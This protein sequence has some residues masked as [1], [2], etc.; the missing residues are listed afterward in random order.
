MTASTTVSVLIPTFR[1]PV[2]LA[3]S[4][5]ALDAQTGLEA[6]RVEIVV[7]DN[8]PQASAAPVIAEARA[9]WRSALALTAVAEPRPGISHARNRA[10][11]EASAP[12]VVFLDDDQCPAPGW[13]AALVRVA[14]SSGAAAVFGPVTAVL[15][16]P[17]DDPVRPLYAAYFS[18][19]IQRMDGADLTDMVARLG[20]QN[21]LFNRD[22]CRWGAPPFDADLG[23][24]GGEDSVA[25]RRLTE[26]GLRLAWA[27]EALVSETV[28]AER[29]TP[30]YL[31]RR[32][33]RD[34]QI[35]AFA[36]LRLARKRPWETLLWMGIG[37]AQAGVHA[38]GWLLA[39]VRDGRASPARRVHH[40]A[41]MAGGL[42][43]VLWMGRFRYR[44]YGDGGS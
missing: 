39:R 40:A 11:A 35:R 25:L 13:L 22:Q 10:L 34:G 44:M 6:D 31:R 18:R 16:G 12:L 4:L 33:F 27:A 1:R 21:S 20:T 19:A 42:G 29:C 26:R 3:R 15:E 14:R 41:E 7:V 38:A 30:G 9:G 17:A 5:A 32:R 23:H 2:L 37:L 43:K 36:P 24:I 8:D 28:P